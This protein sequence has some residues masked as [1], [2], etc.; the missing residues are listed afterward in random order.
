MSRLFITPREIDFISDLTKE[1]FKDVIGHKIYYYSIS[2]TKSNV[3]ELY[4]EAIEK[5]FETP[6]ELEAMIEWNPEEVTT[7]LFG[8]EEK[9]R[10]TAF[11]HA[12]DVIDK[13]VQLSEGD[14]FSFGEKFFEIT[15]FTVTNNIFGQ[16][17]HPAG[18]KLEGRESRRGQFVSA[19]FGPTSEKYSDE[20]AVQDTFVQQRGERM[21]HEGETGDKRALRDKGVLEAPITGPKT[22]SGQGTTTKAG[23]SFYDEE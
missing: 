3:H 17:E 4:D 23:N 7:N 11:I 8:S 22:V 14:F 10:L 19:V 5:V 20:N 12:R 2:I 9:T 21:N 1:I 18:Y 15:T 16:I 13:G 6:I